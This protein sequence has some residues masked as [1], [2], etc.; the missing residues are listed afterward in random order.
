MSNRSYVCTK[1]RTS[2]RAAAAYGRNTDLRC[3]VCGGPLWELEWRW[4]IPRKVDDKGW[5]QLSEKVSSDAKRLWP[6]RVRIGLSRLDKV[7]KQIAAVSRQKITSTKAKKLKKL[8]S[9]RKRV[10]HEY[11]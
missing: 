4:R 11:I 7:D 10:I 1:C 3:R 2:R 5:R 9:E 6:R 8:R